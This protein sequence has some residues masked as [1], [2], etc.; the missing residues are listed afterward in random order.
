[1]ARA[2]IRRFWWP[3]ALSAAALAAVGC[4]AMPASSSSS[5]SPATTP[6]ATPTP[7][8]QAACAANALSAAPGRSS[9]ATGHVSRVVVLTNTS[10]TTCVLNGY[11][12]LKRLDADAG[13]VPTK[14]VQ[15][16][17]FSF[18]DQP[19]QPVRL[20]PQ[21]TASFATDW[22][23]A[24]GYPQGCPESTKL[25]ITPPGSSAPL[26]IDMPVQACPDGTMHVSAIVPGPNGPSR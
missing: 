18:P 5:P 9:A 16:G 20:A 3:A 15:G 25:Q 23:T 14:V 26:T 13:P 21:G 7:S 6:S 8:S 19:P 24:T 22:A 10:R 17:G 2:R 11:P 12:D 1:M 4:G